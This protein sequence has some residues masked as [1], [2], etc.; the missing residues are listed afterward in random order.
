MK[1]ELLLWAKHCFEREFSRAEG[2]SIVAILYVEKRYLLSPKL[3]TLSVTT[4]LYLGASM[5]WAAPSPEAVGGAEFVKN[6][7][8]LISTEYIY[9]TPSEKL[10]GGAVTGLNAALKEKKLPPMKLTPVSAKGDF[11]KASKQFTNDFYLVAEK[12]PALLK[13]Q[14][15]Q[16]AAIRGM[17]KTLDDPYTVYMNPDEFG[18]LK[19]AMNG[20]NFG[21]LG[22]YIELDK[23]NN[24]ALTVIEPMADTPAM[25]GGLRSRDVILKIDDTPTTNTTLPAAQNLL[26]GEVGSKVKLHIQRADVAPFWVELV[27]D[28]IRVSSVSHKVIEDNGVKVGYLKLKVFGERT[29]TELEDALRETSKEGAQAFILDLRNNGGGY[30]NAAVDVCSKFLDTGSRVVSVQERG[31]DENFYFSH[32]NLHSQRPLVMLVNEFS[33]SASEITAGAMKDLNR[34]KLVGN[35]TFGKGS[36]QKIFPLPNNSAMKVTTAHYHTPS[37]TDINKLGIEPDV[38]VA[39]PI[40]KVGTD[41]DEQ[42]KKALEL[43]VGEVKEKD[44]LSQKSEP[45]QVASVEDELRILDEHKSQGYTVTKRQLVRD[46]DNLYEDIT[47]EKAGN[48]RTLRLEL[49]PY[50]MR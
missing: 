1:R 40:Q 33:A 50:L 15:L 39:M 47:L 26:R 21:G 3:V 48:S 38:K 41:E 6:L 4:A 32:P 25:R 9:K 7:T 45:L 31:Q 22:I 2:N 34:A 24:G 43:A 30:I 37:G 8:A 17:L 29:N 10:F 36:V 49:S 11:E 13:D 14:Y 5:A 12:H 27:R 28:R 16:V 44:S 20:G 42:L 18:S 19:E 46:K 23:A 35:K